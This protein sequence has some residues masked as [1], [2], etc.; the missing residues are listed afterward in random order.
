MDE[1]AGEWT[2]L[3]VMFE[4]G[5]SRWARTPVSGASVKLLEQAVDGYGIFC[6]FKGRERRG[7]GGERKAAS[8]EGLGDGALIGSSLRAGLS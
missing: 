2:A 8:G 3:R 1:T 7:R 5:G 6:S 4:G